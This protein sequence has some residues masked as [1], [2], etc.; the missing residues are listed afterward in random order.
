MT[1][2][3]SDFETPDNPSGGIDSAAA[4]PGAGDG[5]GNRT[6]SGT[7]QTEPSARIAPVC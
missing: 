3:R 2:S 1:T 6:G 7:A 4:A 5:G